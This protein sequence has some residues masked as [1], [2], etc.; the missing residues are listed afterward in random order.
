MP[1]PVVLGIYF[2]EYVEVIEVAEFAD[3]LFFQGF[4]YRAAGLISVQALATE[5]TRVGQG[6]KLPEVMGYIMGFQV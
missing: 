6:K 2:I 1:F 5:A 3:F 4:S